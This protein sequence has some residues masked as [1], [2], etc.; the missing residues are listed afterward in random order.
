M[1]H[2][3]TDPADPADP[4]RYATILDQALAPNGCAVIATFTD[5]GPEHCSGLPITRYTADS[6]AQQFPQLHPVGAEREEHHTPT[7]AIQPFAWLVL[8]RTPH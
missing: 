6:L 5:D 1:I 7:A 4:A 3:P 8:C 2:F